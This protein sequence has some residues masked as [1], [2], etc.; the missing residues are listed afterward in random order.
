MKELG[1]PSD[2]KI[3]DISN[4][5]AEWESDI[6]ASNM[7]VIDWT[8]LQVSDSRFDLAWTLMLITAYE[9]EE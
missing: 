1:Y 4:I 7:E 5:H 6:S 9:G 2:I 3:L 8:D